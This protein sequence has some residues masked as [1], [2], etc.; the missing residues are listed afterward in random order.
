MNPHRI[1]T[2]APPTREELLRRA[3]ALVP[4]LRE[5]AA[6]AEALRQIP[7]ETV[8]DLIESR[9]MRVGNPARYGGIGIDY[10][11]MYEMAWEL[12]RGCGSTAWCY[13]IWTFHTW[14]VGH[15]PAEGQEDYFADGPD[16]LCSSSF[17]AAE[18]TAEPVPGGYR[19]RGHW[20]FSSGCDAAGWAVLGARTPQ[21]L[22]W[23]LVPRSDY[24]IVDTWFVSGLCGT[25]SKDIVIDDAFVPAHRTADPARAGVADFTAWDLH[26]QPTYRVP[27]WS[28]SGWDLAAPLIGIAQGAIDEFCARFQGASGGGRTADPV[29][30]QLRL[31]EAAA[32]V[33]SAR[34]LHRQGIRE[35]LAKG[36]RGEPFSALDQA[37]YRRDKAFIAKLCV[38]AVNRLFDASGGH[39]LFAAQ[40]MQRLHRDAHAAAHHFALSWDAAGQMYGRLALETSAETGL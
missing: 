9:T 19:L 12:G 33:D 21:G 31:A 32:E 39:A 11:A 30:L 38:Q 28:I 37:R 2:A 23:V 24:A 7:A 4:V 13:A 40:A 34:A 1:E 35:I 20:Q 17:N 18:A 29:A 3:T 16:T 14:C 27:L 22:I 10:D 36:E 8:Q 6:H 15:F 26:R 5:R 25:G